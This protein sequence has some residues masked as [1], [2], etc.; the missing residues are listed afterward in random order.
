M[1]FDRIAALWLAGLALAGQA[2]GQ[3]AW[4][5]RV[6]DQNDSP[7]AGARVRVRQEAWT[8]LEAES[9]PTGSF[10][11]AVPAPGRYLATVDHA[12]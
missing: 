12:G 10:V 6:V 9:S 5:G 4:S 2:S 11:I 8:A 3:I 7:V 1:P